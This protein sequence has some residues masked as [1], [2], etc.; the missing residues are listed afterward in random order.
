LFYAIL[1]TGSSP[2]A[3]G[4]AIFSFPRA[5]FVAFGWKQIYDN[6]SSLRGLIF[7]LRHWVQRAIRM[8]CSVN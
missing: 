2:L 7:S 6:C 5:C 4:M 1:V 8:Q 3:T